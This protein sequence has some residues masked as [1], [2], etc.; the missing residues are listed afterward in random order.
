MII[1]AQ[2]DSL[3]KPS[4]VRS[5]KSTGVISLSVIVS[6]FVNALK[7]FKLIGDLQSS[8]TLY[9]GLDKLPQVLKEKW[10]FYVYD[11][12]EDWPYLIMFEKRTI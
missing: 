8:W 10:W 6:S 9:I 4:Q 5:Y 7:E 3:R 1:D 2:V 11:K 12:D